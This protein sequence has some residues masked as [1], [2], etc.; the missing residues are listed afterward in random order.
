MRTKVADFNSHGPHTKAVQVGNG[1]LRSPSVQL[2]HVDEAVFHAGWILFFSNIKIKPACS[3]IVSPSSCRSLVSAQLLP[4]TSILHKRAS[5]CVTG[6]LVNK[7]PYSEWEKRSGKKGS[8]P[9][10]SF[11]F[12]CSDFSMPMSKDRTNRT[13]DD[14]V[15]Q[16]ARIWLIK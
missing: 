3:P 2:V 9:F 6:C 15:N 1:L 13:R 5:G 11:S 12:T 7:N 10:F 14:K 4:P 8:D 16:Q